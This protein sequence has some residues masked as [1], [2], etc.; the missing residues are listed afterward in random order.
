MDFLLKN[1]TV[2]PL[3]TRGR[4]AP[5]KVGDRVRYYPS[6]LYMAPSG[7]DETTVGEVVAGSPEQGF[8]VRW[9]P[10][11]DQRPRRDSEHSIYV[12]EV[13]QPPGAQ[14]E[15]GKVHRLGKAQG[16][17]WAGR[18][19]LHPDHGAELDSRAGIYEFQHRLP[20][21]EAERRAHEDYRQDQHRVAAAHHLR[22]QRAAMALGD[23]KS[24]RKHGLMYHLHARALGLN[25]LDPVHESIGQHLRADR[26]GQPQPGYRFRVHGADALLLGGATT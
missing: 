16:H 3:P 4:R 9:P 26:G 11:V 17:Q 14:A 13:S 24:A 10:H 22:G 21:Q 18:P 19:I 6:A 8:Q 12:Y 23:Q 25:P 20:R 15:P 2:V 7:V 5:P 1:G